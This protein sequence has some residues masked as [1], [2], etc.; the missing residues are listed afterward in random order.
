MKT[1]SEV[2]RR[3]D[4]L[5]KKERRLGR[6]RRHRNK[7]HALSAWSRS[8]EEYD[9]TGIKKRTLLLLFKNKE[10]TLLVGKKKI[11]GFIRELHSAIRDIKQY[12]PGFMSGGLIRDRLCAIR[13]CRWVL[14]G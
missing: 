2:R 5:E 10:R 12:S 6:V 8:L 7:S 14:Y 1:A 13:Q 11:L 3:A 9:R 4:F